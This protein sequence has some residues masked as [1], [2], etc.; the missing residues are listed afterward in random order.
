MN[1]LIIGVS[2]FIGNHLYHA[3]SQHGHHLSGCSRHKVAGINWQ[4]FEFGQ[5]VKKWQ[6]LLKN[7]DVVI[8]AAGIYEESA[9]AG[10]TAVHDEGPKRLFE[11]CIKQRTR[12]IQISAIGAEKENP[13]SDFLKSKRNADQFLLKQSLPGQFVS[14]SN[15]SQVVL[16][17]GIVLGEAGKS[18]QQL[19]LLARQNIRP[20]VFGRNKKLPLISI[21]QLTEYIISILNNWPKENLTQVLLAKEET[22]ESLIQNLRGWM[23]LGEKSACNIY[24]PQSIINLG[25]KI[26]PGLSIG[27]FNRES[28]EML[29]GY[30]LDSDSK[31]Y[32]PISNTTASESLIK[33]KAT[34]DFIKNRKLTLLFY[35]NLIT[36]SLIWIMSGVSSLV[37]F[38][39]SLE[40]ISFLDVDRV[41]GDVLII[42]ASIADILLGVLLWFSSLR[43]WVIYI[44]IMV[45]LVYSFI[46]SMF[47]PMYWLHP[48]APVIKN[49]AMLILALYLLVEERNK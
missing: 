1:I 49:L 25:F 6:L 14:S 46:I 30:T 23:N 39:Q 27:A 10:F 29:E 19:S 2:G 43:R 34:D 28:V 22:M 42:T 13:P 31:I 7:I 35:L 11:L 32:F 20:F 48:F 45:M 4:S 9:S 36:L 47:L 21:D 3:L 5:S 44:Q 33:N 26:F 16:Y 12:V 24:L 37:N 15:I 18:A 8:N 41:F 17:P 40:L 38:E